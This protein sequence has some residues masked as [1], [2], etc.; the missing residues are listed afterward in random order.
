MDIESK[1]VSPACILIVSGEV[2]GLQDGVRKQ[3]ASE[4]LVDEAYHEFLVLKVCQIRRDRR[5]QVAPNLPESQ[6][7][8]KM[9]EAQ[10]QCS[11]RWQRVLIE[12][13][14]RDYLKFLSTKKAIQPLNRLTVEAHRRDEMAH[15]SIFKGLAKCM[16]ASLNTSELEFFVDVLP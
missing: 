15:G 8:V 10:A 13:F 12:V 9:H 1:I 2:P 7:I 3:I 4:T 14:I 5:G 11:P 16:Y 6:L